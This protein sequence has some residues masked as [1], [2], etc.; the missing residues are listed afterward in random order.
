VFV[1][2]DFEV[3]SFKFTLFLRMEIKNYSGTIGR[4]SE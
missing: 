2:E 4:Y 3:I 1:V